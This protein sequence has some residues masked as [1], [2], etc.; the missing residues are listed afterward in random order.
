MALKSAISAKDE[1]F[2]FDLHLR[3]RQALLMKNLS[4]IQQRKD[5]FTRESNSRCH[6]VTSV[7]Q[8]LRVRHT[9]KWR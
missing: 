8:F 1:P 4:R 5:V 9:R 6:K 3:K 2:E 7:R